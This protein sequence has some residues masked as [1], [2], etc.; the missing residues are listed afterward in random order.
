MGASGD[1]AEKQARAVDF[2][3]QGWDCA[4]REN[5]F[6]CRIMK[7]LP[8]FA[9]LASAM[10]VDA[11]AQKAAEKKPATSAPA[12]APIAPPKAGEA[13]NVTPDEAQKLIEARKDLVVL[14]VRTPEE[15]EMGHIAGA[16]NLSF[17]D[18]EFADQL[19]QYEGKPVLVHCA[20]GSRSAKAVKEM[21]G[22]KFP[23]IYHMN[24]GMKAWVD[25]K[26]DVVKSAAPAQ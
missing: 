12:A 24:G 10:L 11:Q 6:H 20:A 17:I 26:K 18:R 9:C 19:K 23:E 4:V 22:D 2:L 8:L 15:Y 21:I 25:A 5:A 14:D 1:C 13:R 16:R 7:Y 3:F